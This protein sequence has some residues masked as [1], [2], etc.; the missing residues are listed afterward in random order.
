MKIFLTATLIA[1]VLFN[2]VFHYCA[3]VISGR[4]DDA[5]KKKR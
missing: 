3:F 2:C 5:E 4:E 1:F